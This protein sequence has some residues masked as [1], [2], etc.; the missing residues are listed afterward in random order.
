MPLCYYCGEPLPK[1]AKDPYFCK[2]KHAESFG[3]LMVEAGYA[4][5]DYNEALARQQ[6]EKNGSASFRRTA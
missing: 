2:S 3:R 5:V 1:K 6:A 4:T